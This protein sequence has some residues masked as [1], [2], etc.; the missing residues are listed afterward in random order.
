MHPS[1]DTLVARQSPDAHEPLLKPRTW[2]IGI[3]VAVLTVVYY[4]AMF[5]FEYRHPIDK[6][7]VLRELANFLGVLF[8]A[9]WA[10]RDIRIMNIGLCS[11]LFSLWMEVV[12]EFT[13][14]PL[15]QG[16]YVPAFFGI[17][18]LVLVAIGV[19]EA[20][21]RRIS[22]QLRRQDA[23]AALRGNAS[24]LRAVVE[25]TP[26]AVWVKGGDGRYVLANSAFAGL[27]GKP[28]SAL[29]GKGEA[30]L[31][32]AEPE[33]RGRAVAR[34]LESGVAERF[35]ATL[36]QDGNAR[37][38]LVSR[39]AFRD[40]AGT[41]IGVLG[42]ARDISDRKAAEDRLFQQAHHD[43]LTGVA[44]RSAFLERLSRALTRWRHSPERLFAIL[45]ID[46]DGF[47]D[48]NDRYGHLTG[49]KLLAT[50]ATSLAKW[51][52]PG[53]FIARMSGDEFT[54]LLGE[55][56]GPED[57]SHIAQRIIDGLKEPLSVGATTVQVTASIGVAMC[58]TASSDAVALVNAADE[59]MYRAKR[60]GKARHEMAT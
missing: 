23:E 19:R 47:K 1:F 49:D 25:T 58:T 26:D 14:E 52:R 12:D 31:F 33:T 6:V 45:F 40:E 46:I 16:T 39:S 36:I 43:A 30:E 44:N 18:G 48:V 17:V 3:I 28:E 57:A 21:R 15:W 42:I 51:L 29:I 24:L 5:P 32:A 60:M 35:E 37:T 38:F 34:A 20:R 54:V 4:A 8:V 11:V 10:R 2:L 53:D 41:A 59:A 55:V 13:A 27:V 22:D 7:D 50:F 56:A 9:L